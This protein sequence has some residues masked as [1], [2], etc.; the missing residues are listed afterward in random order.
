[1]RAQVLYTCIQVSVQ[2]WKRLVNFSMAHRFSIRLVR[3]KYSKEKCTFINNCVPLGSTIL[4]ILLKLEEALRCKR[5]EVSL[6]KNVFLKLL[7]MGTNV[8]TEILIAN[9]KRF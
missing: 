1:M 3:R 4:I 5:I 8:I 2:T 9:K 6:F 7:L